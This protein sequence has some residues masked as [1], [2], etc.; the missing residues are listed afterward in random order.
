MFYTLFFCHF[1]SLCVFCGRLLLFVVLLGLF[2]VILR[3]FL[4]VLCGCGR[5][6][7][8]FKLFYVSL[9][10]FSVFVVIL[11]PFVS[12]SAS[13]CGCFMSG[14]NHCMCVFVV[15]WLYNK[16]FNTETL[17]LAPLALTS[18]RPVQQSIHDMNELRKLPPVNS[19]ERG[20]QGVQSALP[21][22]LTCRSTPIWEPG[23]LCRLQETNQREN[24]GFGGCRV[25]FVSSSLIK[26]LSQ[27]LQQPNERGPI[28]PSFFFFFFDCLL[29]TIISAKSWTEPQPHLPPHHHHPHLFL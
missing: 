12:C 22:F 21:V 20:G 17:V 27:I 28:M 13:P 6:Q 4:I 5:L 23:G 18:R 1:T 16:S 26:S 29:P 24:S 14:F 11:Q 19:G 15:V 3:F 2:V 9:W 8:F 7:S 10:S 25:F